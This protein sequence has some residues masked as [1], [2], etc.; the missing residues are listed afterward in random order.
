VTSPLSVLAFAAAGCLGTISHG[1]DLERVQTALWTDLGDL[2]ESTAV[3]VVVAN[4]RANCDPEDIEDENVPGRDE[5]EIAEERWAAEWASALTREGA[6]AAAFL[7]RVEPGSQ[8]VGIFDISGE[9]AD[10]EDG[11]AGTASAA[12]LWVEE[13][14]L[15]SREGVDFIQ[16][17]TD[18]EL[19]AAAKGQVE[20]IDSLGNM[21][22]RFELDGGWSGEFTAMECKNEDLARAI[23]YQLARFSR[24]VQDMVE[25]A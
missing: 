8:P 10:F 24:W 23:I 25:S 18:Y 15:A 13:A 20:T 22:A 21:A 17:P 9:A 7:L 6:W 4:S 16:E 19:D 1:D 3:A 11:E 2:G 12:W 5:E 14:V